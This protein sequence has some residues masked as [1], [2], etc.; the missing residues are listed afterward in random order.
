MTRNLV[1]IRHAQAEAGT[2]DVDRPLTARGTADAGALG[3]WLLAH[4][5]RPDSVVVSPAR[6]ACQTW[7]LAAAALPSPPPPRLD[8]RI[9]ADTVEDLSDVVGD[10]D[11]DVGTLV[12]VGH[13]PAVH[14]FA[15]RLDAG[16]ADRP[17]SA[18]L[19]GGFPS[20]A[21][22]ILELAGAWAEVAERTGVLVE[23]ATRADF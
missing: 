3:R 21:V 20:A 8:E 13:N 7:A 11:V 15:V 18:R 2:P 5:V 4:D 12:L 23:F 14:Q 16:P 10:A 6:R 19:E 17:A 22:A 1:L 9:L